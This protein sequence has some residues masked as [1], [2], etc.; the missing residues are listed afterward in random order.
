MSFFTQIDQFWDTGSHRGQV[1]RGS[2]QYTGG[3]CRSGPRRVTSGVSGVSGR[4]VYELSRAGGRSALRRR[5]ARRK[6]GCNDCSAEQ[7]QSEESQEQSQEE[8]S[9]TA[10]I[11]CVVD[12]LRFYGG[13]NESAGVGNSRTEHTEK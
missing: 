10:A 8:R 4:A 9:E 6:P 3:L 2:A 1:S 12:G 11:R 5:L 7:R 13:E